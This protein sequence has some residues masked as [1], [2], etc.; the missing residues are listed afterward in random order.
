M[1]VLDYPKIAYTFEKLI[2]FVLA[3]LRLTKI[4]FKKGMLNLGDFF[5]WFFVFVKKSSTVGTFRKSFQ[6][7]G[8]ISERE[9]V[10]LLRRSVSICRFRT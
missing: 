7:N 6:N 8:F 5:I 4:N 10:L 1:L 9:L 2:L 3:V